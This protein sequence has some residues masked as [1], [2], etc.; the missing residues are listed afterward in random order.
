MKVNPLL[1]NAQAQSVRRASR[2]ILDIGLSGTAWTVPSSPPAEI[3]VSPSLVENTLRIRYR[4]SGLYQLSYDDMAA[5]GVEGP[6]SGAPVSSLRLYQ[7][8]TEIPIEVISSSTNFSSGDAL[9]FYAAFLPTQENSENELV[10]SRIPLGNSSGSALRISHVNADPT[11]ALATDEV[12]TWAKAVAEQDNYEMFD[13]PLGSDQDHFYWGMIYAYNQDPPPAPALDLTAPIELPGL[14]RTSA[15][16]HLRV[17][18]KGGRGFAVNDVHHLGVFLN[19]IP[20]SAADVVF[21]ETSPQV[22]EFDIPSSFFLSGTN[23][24]LL[25]A[26]ADRV[27]ANGLDVMYIDKIEVE[28]RAARS[29]RSGSQAEIYNY[30]GTSTLDVSGLSTPITTLIYDV[31]SM[32]AVQALDQVAFT[33]PDANGQYTASFAAMPDSS[34]G[35]GFKF[36]V[37]DS[38]DL[39]KP[40]S[41]FLATG[42]RQSLKNTSMGADL[43]IVGSSDLIDAASE[44]ISARQ[45]QGLRVVTAS[46]EQIYAEFGQGVPSSQAIRDLVQYAIAHWTAPA[47][48]YLLFL[49]DATYDTRNALGYNPPISRMPVPLES[50]AYSD[51]GNDNWFAALDPVTNPLPLMA[52]GRIPARDASTLTAYIRKLLDY[53][54]GGRAPSSSTASRLVFVSDSDHMNEGFATE[55][56]RLA[57]SALSAR[58]AFQTSMIDRTSLGSDTA[59]RT[60]IAQAFDS[61]PLVM[62]YLGHGAEDMWAGSSVFTNADAVSLTN[63]RLPI[64]VALNCLNGVYYYPDPSYDSLGEKMLLNPT[65]GAIAFWGSTTLT[66]PTAQLKLARTFVNLLGQETR[67]DYHDVRLGDLMLQAKAGLGASASTVDTMRSYTLFGDPSMPLPVAAFNQPSSSG[68]SAESAPAASDDQRSGG[69]FFS[70][71]TVNS[72]GGSGGSGPGPGAMADLGLLVLMIFAGRRL[73]SVRGTGPSRA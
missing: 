59:M 58:S 44:L 34:V 40:A 61:A 23:Q 41:I 16:V 48:K 27:P 25:K 28:Y 29:A 51:F 71:G 14:I 11:Q 53:E 24:V 73:M 37:L 60:Q 65:G 56:S 22:L 35:T 3:A 4:Q 67:Q 50:G 31:S 36:V 39:L 20:Y 45:A 38:A 42:V 10:L 63:S 66:V 43:L 47:P 32:D 5:A 72:G 18:A 70:C 2:I 13:D 17:Y 49:G 12:G 57:S 64:V 30:R 69:G 26:L 1:Y 62:T 15:P 55:S 7:N 52:V 54:T 68:P 19:G 8:G 21:Q 6:F 46:L 9:R 33:G